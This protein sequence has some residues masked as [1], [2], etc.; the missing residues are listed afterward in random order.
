MLGTRGNACNDDEVRKITHCHTYEN[1]AEYAASA[2]LT[3]TK[4]KAGCPLRGLSERMGLCARGLRGR[5]PMF[6]GS[7]DIVVRGPSSFRESESA[8]ASSSSVA[9]R[10][11]LS[12][13]CIVTKVNGRQFLRSVWESCIA[14]DGSP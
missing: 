7:R 10:C 13:L 12:N 14:S 4:T 1:N 5:T 11:R 3:G 2:S 6:R 8:I 9:L